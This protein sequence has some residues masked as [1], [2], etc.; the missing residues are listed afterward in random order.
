MK[1]AGLPHADFR[2]GAFQIKIIFGY[3]IL[4]IL[5]R[6]DISIEYLGCMLYSCPV[7]YGVELW[8]V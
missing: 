5:A 3:Y 6:Q 4:S 1:G 2:P 7:C 8:L